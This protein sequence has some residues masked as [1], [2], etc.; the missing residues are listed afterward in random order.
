MAYENRIIGTGTEH[1]EQLLANPNNWRIHP[2]SQ[3][4]AVESSLDGVGW[5][6][7]IIVNERTGHVV[8]GHMR[9]SVA[10]SRNEQEVPVV[11]VDLT[12]EEERQILATYDPIGA[13]AVADKEMLAELV[14]NVSMSDTLKELVDSVAFDPLE[15]IKA[16]LKEPAK[17]ERWRNTRLDLISTPPI[18]FCCTLICLG[19]MYGVQSQKT[20]FSE[21]PKCNN[22][23]SFSGRHKIDFIDNEFAEYKHEVHS[24]NVRDLKPKYATVRDIMTQQQCDESGIQY[25]SFDELMSHAEQFDESAE[26]VIVI[27]KYDCIDQIPEKY[28]LGY[29]IPASYG[30]TP[31]PIE[32]FKGRRIHLLGGS[33]KQQIKA[34]ELLGDDVVSADM[35]SFMKIANYGQVV[36][37]DGETVQL[38]D[39]W[40][41]QKNTTLDTRAHHSPFYASYVLS[42]GFILSGLK[43]LST[44]GAIDE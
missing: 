31:L 1:P 17:K 6:Q 11:Y 39:L 35:N 30:G 7:H 41:S 43:Q 44:E 38:G 22:T 40:G 25:F 26:N 20:Y 27:P 13:M 21:K 9:A 3:Q 2:K 4:D 10:I 15:E 33:W 32:A 5:V 16:L 23:G 18:H 29:S 24:A 19:F 36:L 37:P 12:D 14:E 34:I 42:A 28:M 8:D